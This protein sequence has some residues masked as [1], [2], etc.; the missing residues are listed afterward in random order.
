VARLEDERKRSLQLLQNRLDQLRKADPLIWL[1]I[2]HIFSQLGHSLGIGVRFED[3]SPVLEHST[4]GSV[5]GDDTVVNDHELALGIRT[6]GVAVDGRRGAV[7]GPAG[8]GDGDLGDERLILVDG[9]GCAGRVI[10]T[11]LFPGKC[12]DEDV[13]DLRPGL[14]ITGSQQENTRNRHGEMD[15][16]NDDNN[17][18]KCLDIVTNIEL[19]AHLFPQIVAVR[20]N[21]THIGY[22]S[23]IKSRI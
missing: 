10:T 8:V 7:S 14:Y 12:A 15:V 18:D 13:E 19:E 23:R 3:V 6:V 21:S 17:I 22:N 16:I 20:N 9:R 2:I 1:R 5:I 11:V 4:E